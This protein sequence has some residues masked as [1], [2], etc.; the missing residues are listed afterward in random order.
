M[1]LFRNILKYTPLLIAAMGVASCSSDSTI[2][3]ENTVDMRIP[4]VFG[5]SSEDETAQVTRSSTLLEDGFRVGTYKY[6]NLTAQQVVMDQYQVNYNA[7]SSPKWYYEKVNEQ[8]LRYWDL[9]AWPYDFR[10]VTPYS[11]NATISSTGISLNASTQPF[12]A[13]TYINKV[14]NITEA[15]GEPFKVSHVQRSVDG[16]NYPD[17]D[18]IKSVEINDASKANATR[19]VHMPFH[20]LMS[21]VG[22]RVFFTESTGITLSNKTLNIQ[23]VNI[24]I[25]NADNKFITASTTYNATNAQELHKGTFTNNTTQTGEY[26]ILSGT[27]SQYSDDL[28]EKTTKETAYD[29]CQ[30]CM[31]QIP[32]S[33][34]KIRVQMELKMTDEY[35]V[36][37][38]F[39]YDDLLSLTP[40]NTDGDSF[41][42]DPDTK[43]IYYLIINLEARTIIV[44]TCEVLPWDD[45]QTTDISVGI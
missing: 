44:Y 29:L 32:Q 12:T 19:S 1:H 40:E 36:E 42:W 16:S 39:H 5:T 10:A 26:V 25:Q 41:T 11:T 45:V 28:H 18:K 20:H 3:E 15:T 43:Y 23:S 6:Y 30:N 21:K 34:V 14:Y 13:Q 24:S 17:H 33:D 35:S 2:E 4:M 8:I 9:A 37:N 22:F 31:L 7:D 38:Y 27:S